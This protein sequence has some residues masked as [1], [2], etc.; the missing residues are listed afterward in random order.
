MSLSRVSAGQRVEPLRIGSSEIG[1]LEEAASREQLQLVGMEYHGALLLAQPMTSGLR[2]C[3]LAVYTQ[4][5]NDQQPLIHTVT[6][7]P[8]VLTPRWPP[9]G[10][11]LQ[12]YK[13]L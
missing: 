3:G 6:L 7:S 1:W 8:T 11:F 13:F 9:A 12:L 4:P 2:S 5:A 10:G